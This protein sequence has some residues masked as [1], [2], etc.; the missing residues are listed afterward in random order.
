[1]S[2]PNLLNAEGAE[3]AKKGR[4]TSNSPRSSRPPRLTDWR[5]G[6]LRC[7]HQYFLFCRTG[8]V[9]S[10]LRP[11][12]GER[13]EGGAPSRRTLRLGA[14]ARVPAL[15]WPKPIER[16]GRGEREERQKDLKL[17]A[18][19]APSAF[20]G[21]EDWAAAVCTSI[22]PVLPNVEGQPRGGCAQAAFS[23]DA[24]RWVKTK[25]VD[26]RSLDLVDSIRCS[27]PSR[28][29]LPADR[30]CRRARYARTADGE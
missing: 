18:L 28:W 21:L 17:S 9:N 29:G 12:V 3:N 22:F 10:E 1:M 24:A 19:F 15:V 16:G 25:V 14:S 2:R 30:Y 27:A 5:I 20:N 23:D 7:A 6:R 8:S 13:F 11:R 4:K 26:G